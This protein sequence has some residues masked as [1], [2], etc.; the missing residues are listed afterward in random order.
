V[1]AESKDLEVWATCSD[2]GIVGAQW[3]RGLESESAVV[4]GIAEH[5]GQQE[6]L[7]M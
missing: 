3:T 5:H 6:A 4:A 1:T 2:R 7:L